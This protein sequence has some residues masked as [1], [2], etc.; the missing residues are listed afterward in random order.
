MTAA[1]EDRA[2]DWILGD[3]V[4]ASSRAIWAHMMGRKPR[5]FCGVAYPLDP[6]D[7]G[8]CDRLF[9]L[10]PEWRYRI[11]EMARYGPV[12]ASLSA[13]WSD[14]ESCLRG[15]IGAERHACAP[16]TYALMREIERSARRVA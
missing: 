13:R 10:I 3:D 5:E 4:G 16:K 14:V 2:I 9:A 11:G 7:F 8:R 15:E 6:D 1:I 12:W